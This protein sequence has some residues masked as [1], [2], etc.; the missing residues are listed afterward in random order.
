[1]TPRRS[2]SSD[3]MISPVYSHT[4][5]PSS[6]GSSGRTAHP[7]C[8]VLKTCSRTHT[9]R[10]TMRFRQSTPQA[11]A[12]LHSYSSASGAA[13]S[14]PPGPYAK[15]APPCPIAVPCSRA[16][17]QQPDSHSPAHPVRNSGCASISTVPPQPSAPPTH[18]CRY[19]MLG[20]GSE[21][22]S[23]MAETGTRCWPGRGRPP[24]T[25]CVM[26]SI[27]KK[28]QG[29]PHAS[30]PLGSPQPPPRG[31]AQQGLRTSPADATRRGSA[32][33]RLCCLASRALRCARSG[34]GS[35]GPQSSESRSHASAGKPSP[36]ASERRHKQAAIESL[37]L[38]SRSAEGSAPLPPR[39]VG[40]AGGTAAPATARSTRACC[41]RLRR[42][43]GER[44]S[45]SATAASAKCEPS[46]A[47]RSSSAASP[48]L[49]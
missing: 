13:R 12:E 8:S 35:S 36:S 10:C 40:W 1:M 6:I 16:H 48:A 21:S 27:W 9:P 14:R 43:D 49:H 7:L 19:E 5:R 23:L 24:G 33:A 11:Q 15:R 38:A 34:A 46:A 44:P 47:C 45:S 4:N 26:S 39:P 20:S 28:T 2:A 32:N 37:S 25:S 17:K 18:A 29:S 22:S 42:Y 31:P 30:P 41:Q 3:A